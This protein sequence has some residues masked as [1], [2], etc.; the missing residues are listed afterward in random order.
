MQVVRTK[1]TA[2]GNYLSTI[3]ES[4]S[5]YFLHTL[6]QLFPTHGLFSYPMDGGS[7]LLQKVNS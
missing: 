5:L 6:Q 1:L 3:A 7:K 4:L 2:Q